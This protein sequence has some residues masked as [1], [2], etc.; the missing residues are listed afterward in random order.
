[1]DP[2]FRPSAVGAGGMPIIETP[3]PLSI[4]LMRLKKPEF[5]IYVPILTERKDALGGDKLFYKTPNHA[6]DVKSLYGSDSVGS[7]ASGMKEDKLIEIPGVDDNSNEKNLS[8]LLTDRTLVFDSLGFYDSWSL[9]SAPGAIYIGETLK[10]Y[11]S[12]HN[13]SYN[14]IKNIS[15]TAQLYY[16]K[17]K[18]TNH[19]LLDI[20]STPMEQLGSKSNKDFIIEQP[21]SIPDNINDDDDKTFLVCNVAYYDPE[22]GRMRSFRKLFPFKVYE[23]LGMK[24]KVNTLENH[25]FVQLDLQNLTQAPS[26]YIENVKFESSFGFDLIDHSTHNYGDRY[27]EHPLLRGETKRLQFELVPNLKHSK[28][29]NALGKIS[30]QWKNTLG[31]SGMLITNPIQYKGVTKQDLEVTILGFS[32][33]SMSDEFLLDTGRVQLKPEQF[34][35]HKP[36]YAV[37]EIVNNSKDVMDLT[38]HLE[39][40]KLYPLAVY[41]SS[42]HVIGELQPTKSRVVYIPLFPLQRGL[43]AVAGKGMFIKDKHTGKVLTLPSKPVTIH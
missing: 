40:D 21:L 33:S 8:Q 29:I 42:L 18:T 27:Y 2:N 24:V 1:M 7:T 4:K 36:F 32:S 19:T 11:I 12:L 20:S 22:E 6:S 9:P 34:Y 26:M 14:I 35:L 13:E 28:A 17:G 31:E 15:V 43:H 23:P 39:S 10:C 30:L 41:G 37:C 5:S 16:G 38:L 3:H 25:I